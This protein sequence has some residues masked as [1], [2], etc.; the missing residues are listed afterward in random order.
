MKVVLFLMA[1]PFL[2]FGQSSEDYRVDYFDIVGDMLAEAQVPAIEDLLESPQVGRCFSRSDRDSVSGGVISFS[3]VDLDVGP[4][5]DEYPKYVF[6]WGLDESSN[7]YDDVPFDNLNFNYVYDYVPQI[8]EGHDTSNEI[9]DRVKL[10]ILGEYL[11]LENN[12]EGV[13]EIRCYFFNP[14]FSSST[15]F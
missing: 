12:I 15:P 9:D 8:G 2:S 5:G 10:G 14:G 1:L 3:K 6:R 7:K 4:I 13:D 11:L